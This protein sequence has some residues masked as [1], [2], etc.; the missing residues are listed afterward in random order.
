M[1]R[2][3]PVDE[4][5]AV[6]PAPATVPMGRARARR[7]YAAGLVLVAP[8]ALGALGGCGQPAPTAGDG[9]DPTVS[10]PIQPTLEPL[11]TTTT[12]TPDTVNP[13]AA[14]DGG[15]FDASDQLT[16]STCTADA[17]GVWSF[18]GRVTNPDSS[19]HTFTV[20]LFLTTSADPDPAVTKQLD[21]TIPAGGSAPVAA[22][23][24][25]TREPKGVECLAGVT[26]KDQ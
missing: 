9:I 12:T 15:L 17:S 16:S 6:L 25:A 5:D 7:R 21:V 13:S 23:A 11:P 19:A 8:L 26:V 24:F 3:D 2:T 14:S 22:K 20:A 1:S 18:S 10:V 4:R